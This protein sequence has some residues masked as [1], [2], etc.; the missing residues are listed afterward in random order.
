MQWNERLFPELAKA[1]KLRIPVEGDLFLRQ[2]ASGT[3]LFHLPASYRYP[4]GNIMGYFSSLNWNDDF[5][6]LEK[7]RKEMKEFFIIDRRKE[8]VRGPFTWEEYEK[9]CQAHQINMPLTPLYELDWI[10]NI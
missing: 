3:N 2:C 7:E 10:V 5:I 4:T 9:E 1:V 6:I 8:E